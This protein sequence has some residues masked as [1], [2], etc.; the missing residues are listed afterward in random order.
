MSNISNMINVYRSTINVKKRDVLAV[1]I[2]AADLVS[3]D[4]ITVEPEITNKSDAQDKSDQQ[5]VFRLTE[6]GTK[7]GIA[8]GITK[9]VRK[10]I[11]K[12]V[13]RMTDDGRRT[14][15]T[16]NMWINTRSINYSQPSQRGRRGQ[17][18]QKFGGSS[19]TSR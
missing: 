14:T 19:S 18:Q 2:A 5:N 15:E 1:S 16:S 9:I 8:E 11:K 13:L 10:D 3:N 17:R 6:I 7:K 12:P 4:N